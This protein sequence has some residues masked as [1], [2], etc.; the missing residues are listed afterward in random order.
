MNLAGCTMTVLRVGEESMGQGGSEPVL[1]VWPF[2]LGFLCPVPHDNKWL[3]Q[4]VN[5]HNSS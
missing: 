1:L 5:L 4:G 2:K 3:T